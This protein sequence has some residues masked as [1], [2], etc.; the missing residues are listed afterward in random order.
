MVLASDVPIGSALSS[1]AAVE[2]AVGTALRRLAGLELPG[3]RLAQLAQRAENDFVGMNCGI[4][5]QFISTLA[6]PG[7]PHAA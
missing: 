3:R 7:P 1:S 4:M 2:V 5:D 6:E